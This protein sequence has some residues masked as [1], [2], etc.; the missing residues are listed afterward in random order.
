[1]AK[2]K[3]SAEN[4]KKEPW[5][6]ERHL[7]PWMKKD[8]DKDEEGG[9]KEEVEEAMTLTANERIKDYQKKEEEKKK[10]KSGLKESSH[11]KDK[12]GKNSKKGGSALA[13]AKSGKLYP[14]FDSR[15]Y[16]LDVL[17]FVSN[18]S[19]KNYAEANKYL[20]AAVE[21]KI[22][23]RIANTAKKLGF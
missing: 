22:K 6:K 19:E 4:N 8:K 14:V 9:E 10:K 20:Q 12:N 13:M 23:G 11:K 15:Q 16:N 21:S 7:P 2:N 5:K 3:S 18:I 17:Q 1:M